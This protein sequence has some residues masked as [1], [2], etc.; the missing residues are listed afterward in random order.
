M[1]GYTPSELDQGWEFKILRS[2]TGAFRKPDRLN[3]ALAQEARAGW[4]LVEKFDN[5][6]IRLKRPSSAKAGDAALDFD[7]LRTNYG[8]REDVLAL[9]IVL[10]ILAA[11]ALAV[12]IGVLVSHR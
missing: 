6:R 11:I 10:S 7:P 3:D 2:S 9:V 5:S 8:M 4:I 12:L 1:T